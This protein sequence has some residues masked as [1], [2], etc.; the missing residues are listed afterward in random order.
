MAYPF[1]FHRLVIGGKIATTE[2]W[3]TSLAIAT[4]GA[5]TPVDSTLLTAV[6]GA[7][8]TWFVGSGTNDARI[9]SNATLEFIKLNRLDTA[10]HYMDDAQ[11]HLYPTPPVGPEAMI[12]PPQTSV[13][14]TLRTS[15]ERGLANRG[16]MYLPP[17]YGIMALD[18]GGRLSTGYA[19]RNA[20]SIS[21]LING[22]NSIYTAWT[23]AGDFGGR[24][25]VVSKT[26]SGAWHSVTA[27]EGGRVVDTVRS[28]RTSLVEDYQPSAV[29]IAP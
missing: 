20:S 28:R 21:T 14:V 10:G 15:Q 9:E 2:H 29:A 4:G 25:A 22:I 27:V 17:T 5:A 3:N 12:A 6:A 16:R 26:R 23:G 24:V 11:T 8:S 13:V 18:S 19:A 7:V 1:P